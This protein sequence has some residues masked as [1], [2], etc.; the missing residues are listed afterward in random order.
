M[1]C[2]YLAKK[3][4]IAN[5]TLNITLELPHTNIIIL[6]ITGRHGAAKKRNCG[7]DKKMMKTK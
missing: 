5:V 2:E 7:D 1:E 4:A 3:L 6:S